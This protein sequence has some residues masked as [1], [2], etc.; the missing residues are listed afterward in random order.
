MFDEY[1]E[2]DNHS[3]DSMN[4]SSQIFD[5]IDNNLCCFCCSANQP[6]VVDDCNIVDNIANDDIFKLYHCV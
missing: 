2:M 1:H 5:F 3:I 6:C 4:I